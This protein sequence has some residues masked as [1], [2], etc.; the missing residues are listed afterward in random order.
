MAQLAQAPSELVQMALQLGAAQGRI[1]A[2]EE[3]M[4]E[5]RQDR[6]RWAALALSR[7]EP[8]RQ[9]PWWW[10]WGRP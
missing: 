10:P 7:P 3:M 5:L 6:D 1:R 2:L 4:G 9:Q 8:V